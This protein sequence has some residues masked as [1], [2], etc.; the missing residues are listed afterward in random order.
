MRIFYKRFSVSSDSKSF[1]IAHLFSFKRGIKNEFLLIID[2]GRTYK[3]SEFSHLRGNPRIRSKL[4]EMIGGNTISYRRIKF[5]E[6]FFFF[7][8]EDEMTDFLCNFYFEPK[9]GAFT[10]VSICD[11]GVLKAMSDFRERAYANG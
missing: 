6:D 5:C 4:F 10:Q 9:S 11:N 2:D 1:G 3:I 7:L 8:G